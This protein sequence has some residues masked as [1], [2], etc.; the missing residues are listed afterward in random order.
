MLLQIGFNEL[1][2]RRYYGKPKSYK[3]DVSLEDRIPLVLPFLIGLVR[4]MLD[5]FRM[6]S[7]LLTCWGFIAALQS[8]NEKLLENPYLQMRGILQLANDLGVDL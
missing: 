3:P 8:N 7:L 6:G 4:C 5:L 1:H 2:L